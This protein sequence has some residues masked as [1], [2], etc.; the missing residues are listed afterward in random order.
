[1][2]LVL[3]SI[4][5]FVVV[6]TSIHAGHWLYGY[7]KKTSKGALIEPSASAIGAMMGLL[8]FMLAFAF[9]MGAHRLDVRKQ[10]LLEEMNAIGTLH[11]RSDFL[12]ADE[13]NEMKTLLAVYT[14][15]RVDLYEDPKLLPDAMARSEEIN[16]KLWSIVNAY[17]VDHLNDVSALALI[18][19]TNNVIDVYGARVFA[20]TQHIPVIIWAVLVAMTILAMIAIGYQMGMSGRM[21]NLLSIIMALTFSAVLVLI[22]DLDRYDQGFFM[23][24]DQPMI[25]F[26]ESIKN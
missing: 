3:I 12:P 26:Y 14:K 4:I 11:M 20:G 23:L 10:L 21:S 5:T 9:S 2:S 7:M 6:L 15:L 18:E 13:G 17:G 22:A 16:E 24:P 19:A 25:N 1:M 8:A